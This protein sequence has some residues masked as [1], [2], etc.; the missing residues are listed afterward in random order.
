MQNVSNLLLLKG[1]LA[2]Y[3]NSFFIKRLLAKGFICLFYEGLHTKY[4][5]LFCIKPFMKNITIFCLWN[6]YSQNIIICFLRNVYLQ[7]ISYVCFMQG[8]YTKYYI[9]P[10]KK[11]K[12]LSL[13]RLSP[14]H[15]IRY[16][17]PIT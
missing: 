6:V 10:L 13:W 12:Y 14:H 1:L 3:Y 5:K 9:F 7:K 17:F 11:I 4:Y 15:I 16:D 8:L 2:K